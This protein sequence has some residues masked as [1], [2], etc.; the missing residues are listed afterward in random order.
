VARTRP[1]FPSQTSWAILGCEGRV[2]PA[3]TLASRRRPER[4]QGPGGEPRVDRRRHARRRYARSPSRSW[5]RWDSCLN[6]PM[7]RNRNGR[8]SRSLCERHWKTR[9]NSRLQRRAHSGDEEEGPAQTIHVCEAQTAGGALNVSDGGDGILPATGTS[10]FH[11]QDLQN[12]TS[13]VLQ[14]RAMR[15][16]NVV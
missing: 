1:E 2:C 10:P 8:R 5:S 16:M 12:A 15:G 11:R 14:F 3:Q 6:A 9:A 13:F 7:S 4:K